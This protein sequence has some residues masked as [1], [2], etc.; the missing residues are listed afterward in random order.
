MF[1]CALRQRK[2]KTDEGLN[3]LIFKS[4]LI[5]INFKPPKATTST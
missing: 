1:L 2:I 3:Y 4:M 5:L